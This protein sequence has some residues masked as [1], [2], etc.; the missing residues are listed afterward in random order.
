MSGGRAML[1]LPRIPAIKAN[2]FSQ[3]RDLFC[4]FQKR[5]GRMRP[6][7]GSVASPCMEGDNTPFPRNRRGV[8][9]ALWHRMD[10]AE[11][12]LAVIESSFSCHPAADHIVQAGYESLPGVWQWQVSCRRR[13]S[14]HAPGPSCFHR[15][16]SLAS[17]HD[18]NFPALIE[19]IPFH[20][21]K[22]C[23]VQ[24]KQRRAPLA[25]SRNQISNSL[26]VQMPAVST[27]VAEKIGFF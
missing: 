16:A 25:L 10:I 9:P 11:T 21:S 20:L 5:L 1:Q 19:L 13:R 14:V 27:G 15:M 22:P 12:L 24:A 2:S 6:G 4:L 18:S 7:G 23:R 26:A 17:M 8:P 3:V